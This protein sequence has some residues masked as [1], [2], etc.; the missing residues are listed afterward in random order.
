MTRNQLVST[1]LANS[2]RISKSSIIKSLNAADIC[3][4][5]ENF[6][7]SGQN[8]TNSWSYGIGTADE[9]NQNSYEASWR[10]LTKEQ[11]LS[12]LEHGSIRFYVDTFGPQAGQLSWGYH[13]YGALNYG[14]TSIS[15]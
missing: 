13:K 7:Q 1:I 5:R 9:Y 8:Q 6:Y 3:I 12:V 11:I 14:D 10:E 4:S 2:G 15:E